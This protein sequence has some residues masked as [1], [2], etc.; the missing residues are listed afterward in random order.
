MTELR[1][2]LAAQ[3]EAV[4]R[5]FLEARGLSEDRDR[6][7][8][9]CAELTDAGAEAEATHVG[10]MNIGLNNRCNRFATSGKHFAT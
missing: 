4:Q 2:E 9:R 7:E 1:A 10:A 3:R 5:L 6:L 8:R